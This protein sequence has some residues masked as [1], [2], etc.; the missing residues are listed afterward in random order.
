MPAAVGAVPA[1]KLLRRVRRR[2]ASRVSV[3]YVG[4]WQELVDRARD[5]GL[6]V[7]GRLSRPSQAVALGPP[8]LPLA[9]T[10]DDAVFGSGLASVDSAEA[11]WASVLEV[12]GGLGPEVP[13]WRRW[14]APFNPAS[15]RS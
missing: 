12:R 1:Y 6:A 14:L 8:A 11:Y 13:V 4:A 2:R 3:R 7:P 15:L 9:R 5:L 10:A